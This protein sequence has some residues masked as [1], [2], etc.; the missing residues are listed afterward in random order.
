MRSAEFPKHKQDPRKLRIL[1]LGDS[2]INGGTLTDQDD[3]ATELLRRDLIER[4]GRPV[5]VG[6]IYRRKLGTAESAGLRK[7][8]RH[9]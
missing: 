8:V 2:I 4:L 1:V 5:V 9:V 3:L 6:N 7:G